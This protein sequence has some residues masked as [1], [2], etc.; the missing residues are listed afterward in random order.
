MLSGNGHILMM[1][2]ILEIF[3]KRAS[4]IFE[5]KFFCQDEIPM[6]VSIYIWEERV[7]EGTALCQA[8]SVRMIESHQ[9]P[10]FFLLPLSPHSFWECF[11]SGGTESQ[12]QSI[13]G[14]PEKPQSVR[15]MEDKD[16][17]LF[18]RQSSPDFFS[19]DLYLA[20]K[21]KMRKRHSKEKDFTLDWRLLSFW[22]FTNDDK[23]W[24]LGLV[25]QSNLGP[26]W[27]I[28]V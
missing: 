23:N 17:S 6:H 2:K 10:S 3:N 21:I 5:K 24:V 28:L 15:M 27:W 22:H 1:K 19:V 16:A 4:F 8:Q 25:T 12:S 7:G 11:F 14:K 26:V 18:G 13:W 20:A 9:L